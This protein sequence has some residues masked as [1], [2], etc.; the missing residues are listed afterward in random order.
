[1]KIIYA[2]MT[3]RV[4]GRRFSGQHPLIEMGIRRHAYTHKSSRV[5]LVRMCTA[6]T[7]IVSNVCD[8]EDVYTNKRD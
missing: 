7:R 5:R 1:M 6:Y 3:T 2:R 8:C 4:Y